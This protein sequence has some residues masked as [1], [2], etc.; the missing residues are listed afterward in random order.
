MVFFKNRKIL[1]FLIDLVSYAAIFFSTQ[2][3]AHKS[4]TS[5]NVPY[6]EYLIV[7]AILGTALFVSRLAFSVY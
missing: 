5:V 3:A 1:L 6:T 2:F 4:S 7:F